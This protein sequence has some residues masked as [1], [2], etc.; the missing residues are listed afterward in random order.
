M[1]VLIANRGEI[2]VRIARAVKSL[3]WQP[4]HVHAQG[5]SP[6]STDS[7]ELSQSGPGA[8]LDINC[9]VETA[10]RTNSSAIHPG[11]GFLSESAQFAEACAENDID[12][13]GPKPDILRLFGDKAASRHHAQKKGV[14][15]LESTSSPAGI[16]EITKLL[17]NNPSGVMVKAVS[18]GGG[19]GMHVVRSTEEL[20]AVVSRCKSEALRAFGRADLY[21]ER[22]MTEA[23]HLEIQVLCDDHGNRVAWAERDCSIQRRHQKVIEITPSPI[24]QDKHRER[25]LTDALALFD[26]SDYC[27]LATVE[28]LVDAQKLRNTGQLDH[29][30]IEVNPRL[31]VEHTVTEELFHIDLVQMQLRVATGESL[32]ALGL[33]TSIMF[34]PEH[35]FAFQS[36]VNAEELTDGVWTASTGTITSLEV[37]SNLRVDTHLQVGQE[38]GRN[39][40]SLL[41]KVISVTDGDY[42][43]ACTEAEE[44]LRAIRI[45]GVA[46]NIAFLSEVLADCTI[47]EGL[48]TTAWLD[49]KLAEKKA[50]PP[51]GDPATIVAPQSGSVV[52][53]DVTVGQQVGPSQSIATIEAMK[54]EHPVTTGATTEITE[55]LIE[56]GQQVE[57]GQIIARLHPVKGEFESLS[58][59]I[60]KQN[61]DEIRADL[62]ALQERVYLTQDAARPQAVARRHDRGHLTAR[63]TIDALVDPDTFL[64]YGTFPVAAQRQ[65]REIQDLITNTPADGIVTGLAKVNGTDCA[66]LAYDYTVLAGT[67]GYFSH[68]K[69]DR[70][71]DVAR[72]RQIPVIFFAEGGGGRPGE[73]DTSNISTAGLNNTTFAAMGRLSGHVPTIGVVTGRCFAGNA[74]LL[75]TCDVIIA[76]KSANVGMAG[77]AM[78]EGGGLGSYAPEDIGPM[79]VQGPNGVV[80][81]IVD[82]DK[83]AT[84]TAKLYLSF[85]TGTREEFSVADQRL[86]RHAVGENRKHVYDIRKLIETL[87]DEGSVLELR[88]D[89]GVGAI[90]AL[91]RIE[92]QPMGL[93]ANNPMHLGGAIDAEAADKMARFLQLCD[94]HH[95]PVIS[96]CDT[97]GFM[98]GPES[99]KTATVR[100]FSRLFVIGSQ[101]RVPMITVIVRKAY[102]LG[103]QAMAAGGFFE[104]VATVAWPTGEVGAMGLEGAVRLGY[105]KELDAIDNPQEKDRRYQ[106]LLDDHYE[107]GKAVN[108]AMKHE[109]DEVIDPSETRHWIVATVGNH[110]PNSSTGRYIDT[111]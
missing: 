7:V 102:G 95:L 25:L 26:S 83:A 3:G 30:F 29:V 28:F 34:P 104:T 103:A 8:Y 11:Y 49:D 56:V 111:W 92:G 107:K 68:K 85:F 10:Q 9:L 96:L 42:E 36:R 38:V 59:N 80:D 53:I 6:L 77:P 58:A 89:F 101:L 110:I 63:E 18:G 82:D 39:F 46:T 12:F 13:I 19:R 55:L 84:E 73:T 70:L 43:Q 65:R 57:A 45:E 50:L 27:G 40:D 35:R 99:E 91:V 33:E 16:A 79:E 44:A 4:Q 22:L 24:L 108:A 76:T 67:Q 41:A 94:A 5:E 69:T 100:H 61:L 109:F 17:T 60:P 23:R 37:P 105:S 87:A 31:Q 48:V 88:K 81:I 75:G 74:A 15:V 66:V 47:R 32:T 54:M 97:P 21:A 1:K 90:T 106:Q 62:A 64:E 98:V 72:V 14:P 86:L 52:S 93:V 51:K 20:P 2:A 71:L 78:I